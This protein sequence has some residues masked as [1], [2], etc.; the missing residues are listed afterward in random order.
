MAPPAQ[1]AAGAG[2]RGGGA[3]VLAITASNSDSEVM[4]WTA[5]LKAARARG[6]VD[7]AAARRG[8]APSLKEGAAPGMNADASAGSASATRANFDM[9]SPA[10]H[11]VAS[12]L[13]EISRSSPSDLFTAVRVP[14]RGKFT[15]SGALSS[16]IKI[17]RP[18]SRRHA[19]VT[20]ADW[21]RTNRGFERR[22]GGVCFDFACNKNNFRV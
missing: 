19:G 10:E 9:L 13:S 5:M 11:R 6:L 12:A 17:P 22:C 21:G 4:S 8:S 15:S 16:V 7:A 2:R 3:P 1:A 20:M 14:G 18:R